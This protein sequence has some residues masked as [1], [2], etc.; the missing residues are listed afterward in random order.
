MGA[1][2]DVGRSRADKRFKWRSVNPAEYRGPSRGV[3]SDVGASELPCWSGFL[4]LLGTL[5]RTVAL[6]S[7]ESEHSS[8]SNL[9]LR[10]CVVSPVAPLHRN[11][12]ATTLAGRGVLLRSVAAVRE[13]RGTAESCAWSRADG[14]GSEVIPADRWE[15]LV[16]S[17]Q[18]TRS[19]VLDAAGCRRVCLRRAF[20]HRT[21][22]NRAAAAAIEQHRV[23]RSPSKR[24]GPNA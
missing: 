11:Q 8:T 4:R 23:A 5:T 16:A 18:P 1:I 6:I 15:R 3:V 2:E 20:G 17:T 24:T 14:L 12:T 19:S 10:A 7:T 13:A 9:L 22:I 21:S